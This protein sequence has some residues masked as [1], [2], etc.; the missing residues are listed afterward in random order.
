MIYRKYRA[1]TYK[2]AVLKAKMELGSDVYIIGRKEIKDGGFLGLFSKTFTDITVAKNEEPAERRQAQEKGPTQGTI[3][4]GL[5]QS[6]NNQGSG[7]STTDFRGTG[8]AGGNGS[9]TAAKGTGGAGSNDSASGTTDDGG[10]DAGSASAGPAASSGRQEA[11]SG[12]AEQVT[13]LGDRLTELRDQ[14]DRVLE[15]NGVRAGSAFP[16]SAKP[17]E[18]KSLDR[19]VDVLRDND[20]SEEYIQRLRARLE[21]Q[22]TLKDLNTEGFLEQKVREHILENIETAGPVTAGEGKPRI[23]V[24]VGPTGVGKTTTI[25]KLA[26]SFGV[27]QKKKVELLTIDSYR[28]AAVEQLQKYAELMQLPFTP[29]NTREEFKAAVAASSADLI[30][31]DTVG[32]SQRNNMGLAELRTILDGVKT[33][34]DLHLVLSAT[35]KYRDAL[36]ITMRFNQLMY[37]NMII[38]K[39]DETNSIGSILSVLR[40]ER[41]LSYF[42]TGQGVP[43]DIEVAGTDKLINM[44]DLE[45]LKEKPED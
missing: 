35:T 27:L 38:T 9:A 1:P 8:T 36:D 33:S 24:L 28:I 4:A 22:L 12:P 19:L 37:T 6:R 29:I 44:L 5:I 10:P 45:G 16:R 15:A 13:D 42:A 2:E 39:L 31:V 17:A 30:F 26:A 18:R 34:M 11:A 20:F 3:T 7:Q 14:L 41:K 43:D 23:V 32:R 40:P 25:A 21:N